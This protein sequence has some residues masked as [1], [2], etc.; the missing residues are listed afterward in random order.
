[1]NDK[2]LEQFN[3]I[4]LPYHG[5]YTYMQAYFKELNDNWKGKSNVIFIPLAHESIA[6][7]FTVFNDIKLEY[8]CIIPS[9]S[10]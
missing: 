2:N 9:N 7:P 8:L 6:Q 5:A 4:A 1:M 3:I 10:I